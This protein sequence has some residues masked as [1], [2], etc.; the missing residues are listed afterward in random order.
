MCGFDNEH[1][2]KT[3]TGVY[4]YAIM[5]MLQRISLFY[6]G[7][8]DMK[9]ILAFT[10]VA[11]MLLASLSF[12]GCGKAEAVKFGMGVHAYIGK[13]TNADGDTNGNGQIVATAAAVLVDANGKIVKCELDAADYTVSYTS[14]G[15]AVAAGEFL[16]KYEKGEAYAF[17]PYAGVCRRGK[18]MV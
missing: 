2:S 4:G 14:A 17:I 5:E 8:T 10:L 9:R 7:E 12:V 6:K 11:L 16:T 15:E 13:V 3:L 1:M 18:G